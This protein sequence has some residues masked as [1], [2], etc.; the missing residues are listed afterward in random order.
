MTLLSQLQGGRLTALAKLFI[1]GGL[2]GDAGVVYS[3][4][5]PDSDGESGAETASRAEDCG[6]AVALNQSDQ[7][8]G[9]CFPC[10]RCDEQSWAHPSGIL[11][12]TA[13]PS[14]VSDGESGSQSGESGS[15]SSRP[16]PSKMQR[17]H[18]RSDFTNEPRVQMGRFNTV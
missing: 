16:P 3:A 9:V 14:D 8:S 2:L 13:G 4:G 12:G 10:R 17:Q 1:L 15:D 18:A 7:A 11:Q 5:V 6:D